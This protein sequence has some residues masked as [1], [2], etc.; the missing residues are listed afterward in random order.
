M[1]QG[2]AA[3]RPRAA[4]PSQFRDGRRRR[5][6]CDA[7]LLIAACARVTGARGQF[8]LIRYMPQTRYP[9]S[10]RRRMCANLRRSASFS[11]SRTRE[12][13][14]VRVGDQ[15]H[16]FEN[17]TGEPSPLPSPP[18]GRGSKNTQSDVKLA[19][20]RLRHAVSQPR[21]HGPKGGVLRRREID[22]HQG[23]RLAHRVEQ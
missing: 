14:R 21:K 5:V 20:K 9:S 11:L 13:V 17:E 23:A 10:P 16:T 3:V 15:V 22:S 4:P 7:M 18:Q 19:P 12:R 2:W 1:A 8:Y 6:C